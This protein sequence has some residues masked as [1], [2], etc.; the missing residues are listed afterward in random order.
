MSVFVPSHNDF[1][2]FFTTIFSFFLST[3]SLFYDE[4]NLQHK[5]YF[6]VLML[7]PFRRMRIDFHARG[8][9]ITQE[10]VRARTM[11]VLVSRWKFCKIPPFATVNEERGESCRVMR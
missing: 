11:G 9:G 3:F 8:I 4:L 2:F 1:V 5:N 10:P 6:K 7:R